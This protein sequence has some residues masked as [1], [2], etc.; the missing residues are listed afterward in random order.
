MPRHLQ[1]K[2]IDS[3]VIINIMQGMNAI[4]NIDLISQSQQSW[5]WLHLDTI[6]SGHIIIM[7]DTIDNNVIDFAANICI[8]GVSQ[9]KQNKAL[10]VKNNTKQFTIIMTRISNLIYQ[11]NDLEI[12][13]V[14]FKSQSRKKIIKQN[15]IYDPEIIVNKT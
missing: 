8:N 12:G 10:W 9:K 1:Y 7:S 14:K 13:E 4:E 2:D 5:W 11:D 6:P 15:I 3:N